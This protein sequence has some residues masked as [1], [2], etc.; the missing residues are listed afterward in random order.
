MT[1]KTKACENCKAPPESKW[2]CNKT[3]PKQPKCEE[4]K[5]SSAADPDCKSRQQACQSCHPPQKMFSCDK[6]TLTC[7]EGSGQIKAACDS[8]CG[9]FT[10]TQLLGTW[11]GLE[12]K[13]G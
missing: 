10:P 4:C 8:S 9:H 1:D 11:R 3:D 2:K 6:K 7:K 5:G 12:V 13:K